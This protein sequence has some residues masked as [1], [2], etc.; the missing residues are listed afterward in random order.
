VQLQLRTHFES[1][2]E[3]CCQLAPQKPRMTVTKIMLMS[4]PGPNTDFFTL[5]LLV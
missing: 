4:N 5:T 2:A 3:I 1:F